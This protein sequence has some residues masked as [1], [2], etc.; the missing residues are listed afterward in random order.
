MSIADVER[1]RHAEERGAILLALSQDYSSRMTS[2]RALAR[3][4]D[5]TGHPMRPE[6]LQF[7]L[8]YLAECDYIRIWRAEELPGWRSDR[9]NDTRGDT[10]VFARLLARG[11]QLI[12]GQVAPDPS[13]IF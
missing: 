9:M 6:G 1:A 13:V 10:I 12:D 4:L 7:S 11:L 3:A 8:T 5:L 2:V